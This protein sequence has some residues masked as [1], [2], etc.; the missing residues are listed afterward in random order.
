MSCIVALIED[1][2]AYVGYDSAA[3]SMMEIRTVKTAKAFKNEDYIICF[4]GSVR[5]GL[6]L[7]DK[8]WSPPEDPDWL[9]DSV[10][11]H[12]EEYRITRER[13]GAP[14]HDTDFLFVKGHQLY[15]LISDF[16]LF[17]IDGNFTAIGSGKQF[18]I[19]S[20]YESRDGEISPEDRVV[21]ALTCASY[22]SPSVRGP[23][24]VIKTKI[25]EKNQGE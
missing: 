14:E 4:C 24:K 2:V 6:I 16:S 11:C 5:A 12:L 18:A 15:E 20:L 7:Q 8:F 13:D 17:E 22:Y 3:T 19:G 9:P 1:D 25:T 10:R 21:R 23:Y